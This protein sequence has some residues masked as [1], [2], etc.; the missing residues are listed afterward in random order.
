MFKVSH[1]CHRCIRCLLLSKYHFNV[2]YSYFFF[3]SF[4]YTTSPAAIITRLMYDTLIFSSSSRSPTRPLQQQSLHDICMILRTIVYQKDNHL[5][6]TF[7]NWIEHY[8]FRTIW[9][10]CHVT[11]PD[12]VYTNLFLVRLWNK[13]FFCLCKS[14]SNPFLKPTCTKQL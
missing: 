8:V 2:W 7:Q 11:V 6:V 3:F 10:C 1:F 9:K 14:R 12:I 5:Y 4:A 13:H